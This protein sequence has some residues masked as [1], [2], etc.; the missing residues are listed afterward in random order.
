MHGEEYVEIFGDL[1]TSGVLKTKAR[2]IDVLDKKSGAVVVVGCKISRNIVFR[3]IL[4][5]FFV[6]AET[7]DQNDNL[8]AKVQMSTFIIGAGNFGGKSKA[9]DDVIGTVAPPTRSPDASVQLKTIPDQAV[10]YRLSGDLNPLHIDPDFAK[11]AG[12]P[13]PIMHGMCS[14]GMQC[15]HWKISR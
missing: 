10:I 6:A 15:E 5:N 8:L 14:L 11:I 4:R 13:Q 9:S 12:Q 3:K 1:P 2:I 7:F